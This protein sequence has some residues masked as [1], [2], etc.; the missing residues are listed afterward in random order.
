MT[1]AVQNSGKRGP[2]HKF[3]V[4][5]CHKYC[6]RQF[7]YKLVMQD[8]KAL[9]RQNWVDYLNWGPGCITW[10]ALFG[11]QLRVNISNSSQCTRDLPTP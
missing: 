11:F 5:K 6:F 1:A 9:E 8:E 2:F 7:F 4:K 10:L 3:L